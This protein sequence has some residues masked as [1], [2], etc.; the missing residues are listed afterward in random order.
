MV[1][2]RIFESEKGVDMLI[3]EYTQK[4]GIKIGKLFNNAIYCWFLPVAK[5]L[6]VE[7]NF[8]LQQE[9]AGKLDQWTIKQSISR[10]ITWLGKYP[11]E[12]CNILKSI[13][14]HFT[15]TP[16]SVKKEDNRNDFVKELFNQ[17]EAKLKEYDPNY[18]SLNACL[19]N[20]G[21]DICDHWDKVWNEKIMYDVIS[22]IVFG[23]Q[24][25]KEFTWYEAISI[26]QEIEEVANE[27]YG[28]K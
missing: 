22:Y 24:V 19:G 23:E 8:I 27:K 26:L 28:V 17:A 1:M 14:L 6:R 13:L 25:Q 16:W 15:C 21:E 5:T 18:N 20:F 11:V 3:N 9:E 2:K 12:N 10:G 7:A 4:S